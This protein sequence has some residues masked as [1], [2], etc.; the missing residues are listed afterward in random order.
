MNT[1]ETVVMEFKII[2]K[3]NFDEKDIEI[4]QL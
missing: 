2:V 4:C 3:E 1:T